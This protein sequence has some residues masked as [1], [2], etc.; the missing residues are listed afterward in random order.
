[1]QDSRVVAFASRSLTDTEKNYAQIEKELLAV[2]FSLEKFD[3]YVYGRRVTVETDHKPLLPI[4]KKALLQAPKRLQRMLL[5]L[6]RY[7]ISLVY[8]RGTDMHLADTL[9]R[10]P[11]QA[12]QEEQSS[13]QKEL[14]MICSVSN[15]IENQQL[16]EIR[17]KT[18][19][20][21]T[22]QAVIEIVQSGW[23][24]EKRSVPIPAR[25]FFN[26]R[27]ELVIDN[28][29]LFKGERCVIPSSLRKKMLQTAHEGHI[30][31]E[32]CLR[33]A[34][35]SIF[36]PGMNGQIRD[37]IRQCETCQTFAPKQQKETM[38]PHEIQEQPWIKV[39]AD[40]FQFDGRDYLVT[41]DYYSNY[42]EV[43]FLAGDTSSSNVINK[44]RAQFA[45]YGIPRTIHT[46][47]GPQFSSMAFKD[48]AT[49]W[50]FSHTTSSPEHPQ[51]NGKA[52]SAVKTAKGLMRKAKHARKDG[53][54][55]ILAY[56][57]TP[58][59]GLDSSPA[60]RF[61]QRRTRTELPATDAQLKPQ[62]VSEKTG[63][64]LKRKQRRQQ[65]VYNRQAKDLPQIHVGEG[66]RVRRFGRWKRAVVIGRTGPKGR[67]YIIRTEEG[68]EIRRNRKDI[69]KDY[70]DVGIDLT[71]A[72]KEDSDTEENGEDEAAT[73]LPQNVQD[74]GG[75]KQP[76]RVSRYGRRLNPPAY[77]QDY[78]TS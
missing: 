30:G 65:R 72:E 47:N 50:G 20:D 77:L 19:E 15:G 14:E 12:A 43:D 3:Q 24:E 35:E 8:R 1:M 2:V 58:T 11:I 10:A 42:W 78:D 59:E 48:F 51:S 60:Q 40:L 73:E 61:H 44:L 38:I 71:M 46:D 76:Y 21:T 6:Q 45:R 75:E 53:W 25:P 63:E 29:I 36:W 4:M 26:I 9:S 32:G 62:L 57:N 74:D 64:W 66:C 33:R 18:E 70:P 5:Q 31:V 68:R 28:G 27:D 13:F 56:R 49:K 34:R 67:S 54:M 52:E 7:D 69:K 55:A 37:F 17:Q 23:P 39:G 41:V 16:E 22:L